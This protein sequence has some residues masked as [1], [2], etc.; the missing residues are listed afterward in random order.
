MVAHAEGCHP[1]WL[2][3]SVMDRLT[4]EQLETLSEHLNQCPTC[5]QTMDRSTLREKCWHD[6]RELLSQ[7]SAALTRS[8]ST[9]HFAATNELRVAR[10]ELSF[11][12]T[13]SNP[14]L[15]GLLD[16]YEVTGVLGRGGMGIVLQAFDPA[17]KRSVAIKVLSPTLAAQ[18]I[19]RQRFIREAQA[20]AA[21]AH[22]HVIAIHAVAPHHDP[23]YFVMPLVAGP[24][25][26]KRIDD[27]GALSIEECLSIALQV[28]E[29]LQAAHQQGLVHRDV[30][31]ANILLEPGTDRVM[32][33]DFG[34]ARAADDATLTGTGI[35]AGTPLFM[36]PEQTLGD[37]I[38]ARSDLFSLGSVLYTML[39]GVT[40]FRASSTMGLLRKIAEQPAKRLSLHDPRTPRWLEKLVER[41]MHK[42][43]KQRYASA[44]ELASDLRAALAHWREPRGVALPKSLTESSNSWLS[45]IRLTGLSLCTA[46]GLIVLIPIAFKVWSSYSSSNENQSP[47]N[48]AAIAT[49]ESSL[50]STT[51]PNSGIETGIPDPIKPALSPSDLEWNDTELLQDI[52]G[53]RRR[54]EQLD[55]S[56]SF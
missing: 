52:I 45:P 16:H 4:S 19:A 21:V 18:G 30:K 29:G 31:P 24:S 2:E 28:A 7:A 49:D 9:T 54:L 47:S 3:F 35:I 55:Q 38:D 33:T 8:E 43:P 50:Q 12:S 48:D 53:T 13:A 22:P 40:P 37:P 11:L 39:S 20:A 41:L 5:R 42:D 44:E 46:L 32:L 10:H 25:L 1:E 56:T 15:L 26:Q 34:L 6:S 23:P 27:S 17:L 36:A 14:D 51:A